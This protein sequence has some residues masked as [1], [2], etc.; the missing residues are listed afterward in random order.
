MARAAALTNYFEVAHELHLNPLAML[1]EAGLTRAMLENPD[2]RIPAT[3]VVNLLEKSA[4]AAQCPTFGLRMAETRDIANLGAIGLLLTHQRTLREVL[5]AMINYRHLMNE[6]LTLHVEDVGR[7]VII[8][9]EVVTD[10]P[11]HS[12]QATE[13]ALGVLA[14]A[15][16]ALLGT[17][18]KPH[19]VLFSHEAPP[20][21]QLHRR[22][23]RC[24]LEFGSEHNGFVCCGSR[25]G[26][27]ELRGQPRARSLRRAAAADPAQGEQHVDG[28]GSA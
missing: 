22:I 18:W 25:P 2:Q 11:M 27:P 3:A 12:R 13:L 7:N 23:F 17:H 10:P 24:R 4:H 28:H 20:D 8:R 19:R 1:A 26:L 14:R 16:S 9:E 15:A 5:L 21:L 6:A